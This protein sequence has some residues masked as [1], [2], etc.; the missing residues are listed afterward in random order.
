MSRRCFSELGDEEVIQD[1]ID[2]HCGRRSVA[3]QCWGKTAV[4]RDEWHRC[5]DDLPSDDEGT[6][7]VGCSDKDYGKGNRIVLDDAGS[8]SYIQNKKTGKKIPLTIENGVYMMQMLVRPPTPF[9]G[10]AKR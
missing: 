8:E 10:Q 1:G 3:G 7:A 2:V 6:E 4:L 9:Q 5:V